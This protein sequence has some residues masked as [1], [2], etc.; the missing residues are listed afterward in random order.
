MY[1]SLT[2]NAQFLIQNGVD[3]F[4]LLYSLKFS[5][6]IWRR[7]YTISFDET[8]EVV[9]KELEVDNILVSTLNAWK[10]RSL[11]LL[12]ARKGSINKL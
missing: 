1:R 2:I 3:L 8:K 4:I 11:N 6:Q 10:C 12:E 5:N 7:I 9:S